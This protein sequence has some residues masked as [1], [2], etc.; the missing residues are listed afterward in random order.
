MDIGTIIAAIN[1]ISNIAQAMNTAPQL[2]PAQAEEKKQ[3][4][5]VQPSPPPTIV[6]L[7]NQTPP[8]G[9]GVPPP[10]PPMR[11]SDYWSQLPPANVL[12]TPIWRVPQYDIRA[13]Y[14][15]GVPPTTEFRVYP[16][17]SL[18]ELYQLYFG[19]RW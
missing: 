15:R 11:G 3:K 6:M 12:R 1:A 9:V 17:Y 2:T 7:P 16:D 13:P 19:T 4:Q 18:D 10:P 14:F 8:M 5:V